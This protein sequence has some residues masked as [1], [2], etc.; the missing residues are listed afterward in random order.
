DRLGPLTY[1]EEEGEVFLGHSVA[2]RKEVSDDTAHLIDEE[3]RAII[4]RN[5]VLAEKILRDNLEILH[6][7]AKALIKY[8]TIDRPQIDAILQGQFPDVPEDSG[9]VSPQVKKENI[10]TKKKPLTPPDAQENVS[11]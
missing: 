5:Y 11:T 7:M 4:E 2:R 8:E 10:K 1:G 6:M 9:F 3:V